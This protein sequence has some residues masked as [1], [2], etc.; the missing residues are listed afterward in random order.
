MQTDPHGLDRAVM[1]EWRLTLDGLSAD[2]L[3][4]AP[5][6]HKRIDACVDWLDVA[7]RGDRWPIII[8][9][10]FSAMEAILSRKRLGSRQP[11]SPCAA[12]QSTSPLA[13]PSPIR[14]R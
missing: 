8:P 1:S 4:V 2:Y 10:T 14:A 11:W 6:L 13:N 9:A 7:A 5:G 12:W 3:A